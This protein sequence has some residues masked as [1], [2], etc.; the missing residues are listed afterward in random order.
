MAASPDSALA[1]MRGIDGASLQTSCLRARHALLLTMAQDKC[2]IDEVEDSTILV[3]YDYYHHRT[4]KRNRLLSTYYLGV[5]RQNAGEL[6]DA[7]LA[8]REA[9]PLSEELEDYRQLSLIEQ[10]LSRI[11]S[12]NYDHV[13][14]LEYAEKALEAAGTAGEKQMEEY[15]LAVRIAEEH[16]LEAQDASHHSMGKHLPKALS[17][18]SALREVGVIQ[19]KTTGS[20]FGVSPAADKTDQLAVDGMD[21]AAPVNASVIHQSIECV[22]LARE[23]LAKGAVSIICRRLH[24]EEREQDEQFHQLNEGELTVRVLDRTHRLG[25]YDEPFHHAVYRVDRPAGVVVFEK[26]FEFRDY[27][28]IFVHG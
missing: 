28:S 11:F 25:L 9:E 7:A 3:A 5:I 23:Q 8:F 14:A 1:L 15:C 22:L 13:R 16:G 24:G 26:V 19:D 21:E 12:L 10:H 27:L 17:L 18:V 6:I 20:T 2:Y 4:N